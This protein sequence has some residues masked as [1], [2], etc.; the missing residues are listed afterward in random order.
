MKITIHPLPR[1]D[2]SLG[3]THR[4]WLGNFYQD[5]TRD[6]LEV[7]AGA[8]TEAFKFAGKP[9]PKKGKKP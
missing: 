2:H 9:N 5:L 6:D 8:A 7:L 1:P 4:L 3:Y